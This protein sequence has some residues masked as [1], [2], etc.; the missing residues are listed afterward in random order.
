MGKSVVIRLEELLVLEK[1]HDEGIALKRVVLS[2][3]KV[4]PD[5]L[6]ST[7]QEQYVGRGLTS[8]SVLM[9]C[10]I[11]SPIP[12]TLWSMA[13]APHEKTEAAC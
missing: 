13:D 12:L 2:L 9:S 7:L 4:Q 8:T 11:V 6:R 3:D 10:F 1:P 5:T